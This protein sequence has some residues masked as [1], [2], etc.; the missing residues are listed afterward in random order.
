MS[1]VLYLRPLSFSFPPVETGLLNGISENGSSV[2]V[3]GFLFVTPYLSLFRQT[4]SN[5]DIHSLRC[6]RTR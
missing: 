2:M 4:K 5:E 1:P 3:G 6:P